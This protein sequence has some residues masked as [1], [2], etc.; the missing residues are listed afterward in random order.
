M[1]DVTF[2]PMMVSTSV[3]PDR[4]VGPRATTANESASK[5]V[6]S[7]PRG[8]SSMVARFADT[9]KSAVSALPVVKL[10]KPATPAKVVKRAVPA[11]PAKRI[12]I[13][14]PTKPAKPAQRIKQ[15]KLFGLVEPVTSG[16]SPMAAA[17][18]RAFQ[19]M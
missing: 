11:Q 10:V 8:V 5:R 15:A 4:R 14:E 7:N 19:Q 2:S 1:S 16:D 17:L 12:K 3:V 9:V 18:K 13:V 6:A